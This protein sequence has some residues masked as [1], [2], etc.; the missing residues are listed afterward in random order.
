MAHPPPHRAADV[1]TTHTFTNADSSAVKPAAAGSVQLIVTSPPYPMIAMWDD[2]FSSVSP[3]AAASL[4][5]G[6]GWAAFLE[7]HAFLGRV[8]ETSCGLLAPGGIVAINMGDA[9]RTING[10]FSL[11]PNHAALLY[12]LR[13]IGLTTLPLLLWHKPTNSPTKFMGSGMLPGGAYVT[14]EHEFI[15]LA[16]KGPL[17]KASSPEERERRRRSA[18]FWEERNEWFSDRWTITGT[19]QR[20]TEFGRARSAAFPVEL[21][22][23]LIAMYSW[24]GDTVYDPFS[25]TGTTAIA[26]ASLGRNSINVEVSEETHTGALARFDST[27][28]ITEAAERRERRVERHRAFVAERECK[29][30]NAGLHTNVVTSQEREL[31]LPRL[32]AVT[33]T[34]TPGH[35]AAEYE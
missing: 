5:A 2:L 17:R 19:R 30:F 11:Y 10:E 35:F 32:R 28:W 6:D 23:R 1:R 7:M 13:S 4:E 12:A 26:A 20:G 34:E 18:I 25:G 31:D 27:E 24:E 16:R 9:V 22:L 14:L 3:G 15:V 8:W 29:H 33:A 21:P